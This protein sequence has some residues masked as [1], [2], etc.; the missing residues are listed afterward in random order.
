MMHYRE[1]ETTTLLEYAAKNGGRISTYNDT[2]CAKKYL[3]AVQSGKIKKQDIVLQASQDGAQIYQ[4]KD[5][6]CYFAI[7]IIHNLSPHV[8][9]KKR[10]VMPTTIVPGP[11]K[12]K[13]IDSFM[14]PSTYHL[15]AVQ[16]EGFRYWDEYEKV[17]VEDSVPLIWIEMADWAGLV[18]H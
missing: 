5:S 17:L 4:D 13:N 10:F 3:E 12:P 2:I 15:A 14:F 16:N 6:D 8:R 7:H 11:K 9:Y 18:G 1:R